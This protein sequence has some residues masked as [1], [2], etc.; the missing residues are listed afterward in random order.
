MVSG[1]LTAGGK[2]TE[3]SGRL[4][5]DMLTMNGAGAE[6]SGRVAGNRIEGTVKNGAAAATP[7]SAARAQ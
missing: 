4:R 3:L 6:L 2:T 5:G 7:L 1:T